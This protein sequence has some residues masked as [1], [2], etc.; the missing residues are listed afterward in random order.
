ME[1]E[2]KKREFDLHN[3]N[4]IRFD[5]DKKRIETELAKYKTDILTTLRDEK[6]YS[7]DKT[8][9]TSEEHTVNQKIQQ[10]EVELQQ[11]KNKSLKLKQDRES[12]ERKDKE[13]L[14]DI[15]K[16]DAYVRSLQ[17]KLDEI[18]HKLIQTNKE[19]TTL[20]SDL[21]KLKRYA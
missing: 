1:Y 18:N 8:T 17:L 12:A 16:R 14:T 21:N 2:V 10:L 5:M 19:V 20:D 3:S 6:K 9:L 11:L 15:N 13:L 4:K 7:I